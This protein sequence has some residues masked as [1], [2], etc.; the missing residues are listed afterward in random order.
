MQ[1]VSGAA[2][3]PLQA[4]VKDHVEPGSTVVTDG[5][6]PYPGLVKLGYRHQAHNQSA[7]QARGDDPSEPV[8][9]G[10]SDRGSGQALALGHAS[11]AV[12]SSRLPAYL[13]AQ[14]ASP[15]QT[16]QRLDREGLI[17]MQQIICD[18]RPEPTVYE[19]TERG[20]EIVVE[21]TREILSKPAMGYP[22]FSAAISFL[23]LLSAEDAL[24]QLELRA[25]AIDAELHRTGKLLKQAEAVP[26][27][28]LLETGY[29]RAVQATELSWVKA[30]V[31][32]LRAGRL[33]WSEAW[34]RQIAAQFSPD[35]A[36][37]SE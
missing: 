13:S 26:R 6:P 29:F 14:R 25:M 11:G 23:Q 31:E 32:D 2:H 5:W 37:G 7:A 9:G 35:L 18:K 1:V 34:L 8:K 15:Y 28:F 22:E 20:R 10:P 16:I 17:S 3:E 30:V 12:G 19:I 27:L 33:T 36:D 24:H 21:R 4:F